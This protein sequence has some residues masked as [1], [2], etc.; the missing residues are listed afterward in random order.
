MA[1]RATSLGPK[2]L[3]SCVIVL[4]FLSLLL[5]EKPCFRPRKG[6]FCWSFFCVSLCFSLA[7]FGLPLFHFLFLCLSLSLVCLFLPCFLFL[8]SVSG[9]CFLFLWCL[10]FL[11]SRCYFAVFFF[12]CL[13]LFW[14]TIL[15][16]FLLCILFSCYFFLFLLLSYLVFFLIFGRTLLLPHLKFFGVLGAVVAQKLHN[17]TRKGWPSKTFFFSVFFVLHTTLHESSEGV[18]HP[19]KSVDFWK[20]P[21]TSWEVRGTSL[22]MR[23]TSGEPDCSGNPQWEV[24]GSRQGC[25]TAGQPQNRKNLNSRKEEQ[26]WQKNSNFLFFGYF[27]ALF[28]P[29]FSFVFGP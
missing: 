8:I 23:G 13:V 1:Q 14:I 6:H 19:R 15:D 24:P 5:I 16:L 17:L 29:K 2:T 25:D 28:P 3:P 27:F 20:G 26:N 7:F 22:E 10:L 21:R 9:S 12:C 11:V 4:A 18:R